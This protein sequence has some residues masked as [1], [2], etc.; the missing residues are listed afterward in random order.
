[1]ACA[2][3]STGSGSAA[4]PAKPAAAGAAAAKPAQQTAAD[5][6]RAVADFYRGKTVRVIVGFAPGGATDTAA[7]LIQQVLGK[8]IPGNPTVII[9][10]KPGGGSL[11]AANTVYNSEP[12]DGTAI[13]MFS[14]SLVLQ[15]AI[16]AQGVQFD[17]AQY[18]WLASAYGTVAM[19]ATRPD[20][21][22]NT[23]QDIMGTGKEMTVSS[24]GKGTVSYDPPAVL[25]AAL[26]TNFKI[27]TGYPGGAA[28]RLAVKNGEVQGFCTTFETVSG[29][30]RP[31]V[32]GPNRVA[33]IIIW[34][35]IEAPDDPLLQGVP[36][37]LDLARTDADRELIRAMSLPLAFN[38][39]MAFPPGVPQ[40]RVAAMLRALEQAHKDPDLAAA[41]QQA[42][43]DFSPLFSDQITQ[44]VQ[45]ILSLSPESKAKLKDL[46]Q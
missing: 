18:Q 33:K 34:A 27:I 21:G 31:M 37:A 6:E 46:L 12:K 32:E 3:P 29:I 17:S 39:P 35:G 10:N 41:A 15:Q 23:I 26:G 24:F 25:N 45:Q 44:V 36:S 38:L 8:H 2:A 13:G 11:L 14:S 7:R 4:A 16:G 19:C 30:E 43:Q 42:N 5:A 22:I 28:Q 1:M 20:S 9:E 40:D